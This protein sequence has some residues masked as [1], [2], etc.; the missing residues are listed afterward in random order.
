VK[1]SG[2]YSQA[3]FVSVSIGSVSIGSGMEAG[4]ATLYAMSNPESAA[5]EE[6]ISNSL[7][8]LETV[9]LDTGPDPSFALIWLHGL[10]ADGHDFEPVVP[11]LLWRGAPSIRFVFPH[12]PMRAVTLNAGMRMRAW[13]D[14]R[15]VGLDRNQDVA[16]IEQ[17]CG[18]VAALVEREQRRGIAPHRVALAGFSQGG[19]IALQLGLRYPHRIAGLI[20]LSTYLLD[21]SRS[22]A[23]RHA[24][25][26]GLPIFMAHGRMDP[27]V[28]FHLGEAAA[29]LLQG[30]G[31]R[32]D[33]HTYPM[34]HAVCPD[35]IGHIAGWLRQ[36]LE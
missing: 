12:A 9:E 14:I 11:H 21:T 15:S 22:P 36:R 33:W 35:E 5:R 28:P 20:A 13:Y 25:N 31:Y 6:G 2:I 26:Q 19:A 34:A 7:P 18:Q 10:G 17:S 23:D 8:A 4:A 24:V 32:V 3:W 1:S 29:Q 27:L 30:W 16:G